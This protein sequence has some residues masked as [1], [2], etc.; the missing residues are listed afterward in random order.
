[1]QRKQL[2]FNIIVMVFLLGRVSLVPLQAQ[3]Y[4]NAKLSPELRAVDLL[5]RMNLEEKVAQIRHI[6]SGHIFDG[7]M[8]NEEKLKD[9]VQDKCLPLPVMR[10]SVG[11]LLKVFLLRVK[12]AISIYTG[13]R[14]IC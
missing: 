13:F 9:F 12:A 5:Q 1:M 10:T 7:Q 3:P 8:L 11:D 6:H 4:K 2:I 14:N